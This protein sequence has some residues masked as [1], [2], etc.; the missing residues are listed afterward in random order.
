MSAHE[1]GAVVPGKDSICAL[2]KVALCLES[3]EL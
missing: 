3:E 1:A 2:M